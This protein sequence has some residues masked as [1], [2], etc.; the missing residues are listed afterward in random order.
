VAYL[1]VTL[2]RSCLCIWLGIAVLFFFFY[3]PILDVGLLTVAGVT[4]E[5]SDQPTHSQAIS[6]S[7]TPRWSATRDGKAHQITHS[8]VFVFFFSNFFLFV[9]YLQVFSA[10]EF[11]C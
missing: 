10:L 9:S 1:F 4:C 2:L 11:C 5:A 7:P 3:A 6:C 8:V